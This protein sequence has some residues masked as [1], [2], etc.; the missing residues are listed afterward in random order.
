MAF[1]NLTID[2]NEIKKNIATIKHQLNATNQLLLVA[3]RKYRPREFALITCLEW[4]E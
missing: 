4:R 2:I 1:A 3:N